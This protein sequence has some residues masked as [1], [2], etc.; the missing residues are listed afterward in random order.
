MKETN[1]FNVFKEGG[2]FYTKSLVPGQNVYGEQV[3]NDYREWVPERSKLGAG[4]YK[5]MRTFPF[6]KDTITLYL[7]ASSGTTCSHLSDVCPEGI[8]FAVEISPRIFYKFVELAKTR[9][10]LNPILAS[11]NTPEKYAFVPLVD[12]VFQDI[13]QRDQVKIFLKN[14]DAFL[15]KNSYGFLVVKSRS[16]DVTKPPKI[17]FEQVKK[18]LLSHGYKIIDERGLQPYEKDHR[19]FT[20][21]K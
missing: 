20:I 17:I 18:E 4:I 1:Y 3:I 14:C 19:M 6:K 10:N 13:S 21:I 2:K 11:A 5:N 9:N 12:A 15:K 8:I 7:G 16:I